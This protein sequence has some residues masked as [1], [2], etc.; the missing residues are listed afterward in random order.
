MLH[1]NMSK[2]WLLLTFHSD[3]KIARL[4]TV[5]F[6]Q[7]LGFILELVLIAILYLDFCA[8]FITVEDHC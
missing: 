2:P 1:G 8:E 3:C 5:H 4:Y 7:I 6:T